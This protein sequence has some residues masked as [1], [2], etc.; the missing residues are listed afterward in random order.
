LS[1][2]SAAC[3]NV[4]AKHQGASLDPMETMA[5]QLSC[6]GIFLTLFSLAV[7]PHARWQ[8]TVESAIALLLLSILGSLLAFAGLYWLIKNIDVTK[9]LMLSFITPI[10]AVAIGTIALGERIGVHTLFGIA[11]IFVGITCVT[12]RRGIPRMPHAGKLK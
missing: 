1:S 10:V 6:G 7:E 4:H 11:C 8:W 12:F 2:I 9:A 3:A 5:V